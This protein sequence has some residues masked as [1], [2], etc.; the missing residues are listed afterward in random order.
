[1]EFDP[2]EIQECHYWMLNSSVKLLAKSDAYA[3]I[4][5]CHSLGFCSMQLS[6]HSE[7]MSFFNARPNR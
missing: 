4:H 5:K 3:F 6:A 2:C 7:L 1:M